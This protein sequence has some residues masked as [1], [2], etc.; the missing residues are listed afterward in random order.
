MLSF[1]EGDDVYFKDCGNKYWGKVVR[2]E[3]KK[4]YCTF[5]SDELLPIKK[6]FLKIVR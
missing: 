1:R 4:V 5:G 2:V 3:D 6:K